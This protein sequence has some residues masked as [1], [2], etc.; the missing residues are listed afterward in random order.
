MSLLVPGATG[1]QA[2][3]VITPWKTL[4]LSMSSALLHQSAAAGAS[5]QIQSGLTKQGKLAGQ[6][7]PTCR[8]CFGRKSLLKHSHYLFSQD[9]WTFIITQ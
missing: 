6:L 3:F 8:L 5:V 4:L 1:L 7:E 9:A 2:S